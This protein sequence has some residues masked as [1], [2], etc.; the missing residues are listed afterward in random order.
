MS[1]RTKKQL[2]EI[3]RNRKESI[4]ASAMKLFAEN[5]YQNVTISTI[6]KAAGISKGLMYNYFDNKEHLLKEIIIE[7]IRQMM[8]DIDK[9]DTA[10]VTREIIVK[11]IESNFQMMKTDLQYW[12][13]YISVISQ[14]K[15]MNLVKNEVMAMIMP[16]LTMISTYYQNKGVKN[17]MAHTFLVGALMDGIA[18]DYAMAP[19]EFPLDE[20]KE[21]IIEKLL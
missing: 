16:Y 10:L 3:R 15:V 6:A 12:Q 11:L 4:V 20:V 21:I 7:G 18:L 1:P 5:G 9:V 8:A 19:D 14:P 2:K 13:L 17:P